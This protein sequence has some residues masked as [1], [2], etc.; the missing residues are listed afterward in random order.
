[1]EGGVGG[2]FGEGEVGGGWRRVLCLRGLE[3]EDEG[4][5]A[6][7]VGGEEFGGWGFFEWEEGGAGLV[8]AGFFEGECGE[9]VAA[10]GGGVGGVAVGVDDAAVGG[11]A[12][13]GGVE[14]GGLV[15][16]F[17]GGFVLGVEDG[18]PGGLELGSGGG[19]FEWGGE[20]EVEVGEGGL[21]LFFVEGGEEL[22]GFGA[23][24]VFGEGEL[25]G[26]EGVFLEEG[27][28]GF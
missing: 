19:L 9:D 10:G 4:V 3:V 25:G 6:G 15:E 20:F 26:A 1:M 17:G 22:E 5:R 11:G 16:K 21:V 14:L 13:V 8:G 18:G 7:E 23:V 24:G 2:E 28:D 12:G 27:G